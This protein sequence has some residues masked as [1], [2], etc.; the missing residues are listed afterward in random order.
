MQAVVDVAAAHY[1]LQQMLVVEL[2]VAP[3][4]NSRLFT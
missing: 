4:K 2:H 1:W 3:C